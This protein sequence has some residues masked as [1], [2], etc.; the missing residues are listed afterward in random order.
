MMSVKR[1]RAARHV[2]GACATMGFSFARMLHMCI[3]IHRGRHFRTHAAYA[4]IAEG[5]PTNTWSVMRAPHDDPAI[6]RGFDSRTKRKRKRREEL[7]DWA[8]NVGLTA[9]PSEST[10][11]IQFLHGPPASISAAPRLSKLSM[12]STRSCGC[13]EFWLHCS[14]GGT[15]YRSRCMLV[16]KPLK[17]CHPQRQRSVDP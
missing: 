1:L 7:G 2:L 5:L 16:L 9:R 12:S 10:L 17:A 8:A 11:A 13:A 15:E 6:S 3:C 4:F 14:N